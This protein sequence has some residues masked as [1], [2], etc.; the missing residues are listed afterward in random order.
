MAQPHTTALTLADVLDIIRRFI[1]LSVLSFDS[2]RAKDLSSKPGEIRA[3]DRDDLLHDLLPLLMLA[4]EVCVFIIQMWELKAL[5]VIDPKSCVAQRHV[6]K[7]PFLQQCGRTRA[8]VCIKYNG[9]FV[10]SG[11]FTTP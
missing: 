2:Q 5:V 11:V 10:G 6:A 8:C 9:S 1:S 4:F 3:H 7:I